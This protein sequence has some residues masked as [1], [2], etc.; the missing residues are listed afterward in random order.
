MKPLIA[1]WLFTVSST[2]LASDFTCTSGSSKRVIR[3]Q[4]EQQY[5]FVPCQVVYEKE[6]EGTTETLWQ[7]QN[8]AGYCE[9]KAEYLARRLTRFGWICV[10]T[11]DEN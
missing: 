5:A 2:L 8:Q 3:I 1:I 6:P 4:Y 11:S 9:E 7:A 10:K